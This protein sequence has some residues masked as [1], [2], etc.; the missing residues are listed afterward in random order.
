M[1][2][3]EMLEVH[4]PFADHTNPA[5]KNPLKLTNGYVEMPEGPGL[6]VELDWDLIEDQTTEVI[7]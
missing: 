3:A 6:G 7:Q 5:L 1:E 4:P 2:N